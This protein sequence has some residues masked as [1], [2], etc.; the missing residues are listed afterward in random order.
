MKYK[1][2]KNLVAVLIILV[3][4]VASVTAQIGRRFPSEKKIVTDPVTGTQLT[5][6]TSSQANDSKIYQTHP[7]WTADGKWVIFRSSRLPGE[8][9][10]VNEKTGVIVQVSEGGY[11]GML[12]LARNHETLFHAH[13]SPAARAEEGRPGSGCGS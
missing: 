8:T 6:L 9:L 13:G 12:T 3:L 2:S 11:M 5:F 10:A 1:T 4:T 7:Q